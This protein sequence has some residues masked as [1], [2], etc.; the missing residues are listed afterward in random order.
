MLLERVSAVAA[1]AASVAGNT[2]STFGG[3]E[4]GEAITA[5]FYN[6]HPSF[7][8]VVV[9]F[10]N[11]KFSPAWMIALTATAER[12]SAGKSP[13]RSPELEGSSGA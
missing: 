2:G 9:E 10:R 5:P 6:A 7:G 8:S 12:G 4:L 1:A 3:G 11:W 13:R